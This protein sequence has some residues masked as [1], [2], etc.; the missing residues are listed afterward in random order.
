MFTQLEKEMREQ[1]NALNQTKGMYELLNQ[2]KKKEKK[3][4]TKVNL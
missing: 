4:Q 2:F 1:R 3:L